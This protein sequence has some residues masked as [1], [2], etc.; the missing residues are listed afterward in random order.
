MSKIDERYQ[1]G[2]I[3]S[4]RSPQTEMVYYGSTI[5]PLYKRFF[6][7]NASM[8]FGDYCSS[9]EILK[10]GDAYIEWVEDFP[11][12]SKKELDRREGQIQ[13][14]NKQ[15]CVNLCIAGRTKKEHYQTNKDAILQEKKQ[16]YEDNKAVISEKR[17]EFYEA[18]KPVR[19]AYQK[20]YYEANRDAINAK[21]RERRH[22]KKTT[23]STDPSSSSPLP[24][25]N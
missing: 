17:K 14:E 25:P 15:H 18:T 16:Y 9:Q 12:N 5:Q 4:I 11:C 21:K 8:K 6:T 10:L 13:R 2:Q 23:A 3:Y 24:P 1:R 20:E 22:A 7:H 19:L